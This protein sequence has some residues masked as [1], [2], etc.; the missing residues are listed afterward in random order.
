MGFKKEFYKGMEYHFPE[1]FKNA[2]EYLASIQPLQISS[3]AAK[4]MKW[5]EVRI[6]RDR[7]IAATDWT[8]TQDCPLDDEKKAVF[9]AYRQTLRDIPQAYSDPDAVVWPEKPTV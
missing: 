1:T 6:K 7:L 5:D 9:T 2:E 8:Q 4:A 3:D